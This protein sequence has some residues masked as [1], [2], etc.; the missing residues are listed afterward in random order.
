MQSESCT[1]TYLFISYVFYVLIYTEQ[2]FVS[3]RIDKEKNKS[4][5]KNTMLK[6]KI[7][8]ITYVE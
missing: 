2:V 7:K 8:F 1:Y 5:K 4:K 3:F 6:L